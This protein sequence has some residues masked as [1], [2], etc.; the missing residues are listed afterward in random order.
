MGA[1][2]VSRLMFPWSEQS[3]VVL[4]MALS[5]RVYLPTPASRGV[6]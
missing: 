5:M 3:G 6:F 2:Q 4:I 1:P